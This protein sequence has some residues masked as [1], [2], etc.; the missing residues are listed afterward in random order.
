MSKSEINL[1]VLHTT[2]LEEKHFFS[3]IFWCSHSSMYNYGRII[4]LFMKLRNNL[5]I[6]I[7]MNLFVSEY[8][9]LN[10]INFGL[11]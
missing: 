10:G 1:V 11:V 3:Q 8:T 5:M 2:K 4:N 6:G 7:L 9:Q